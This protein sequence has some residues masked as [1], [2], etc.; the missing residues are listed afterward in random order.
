MLKYVCSAL[1]IANM[2]NINGFKANKTAKLQKFTMG[3]YSSFALSVNKQH[4]LCQQVNVVYKPETSRA[5][6]KIFTN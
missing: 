6:D 3:G 5:S 1:E 2:K 4:I